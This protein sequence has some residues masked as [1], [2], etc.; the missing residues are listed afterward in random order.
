MQ[1]GIAEPVGQAW[2]YLLGGTPSCYISTSP[3]GSGQLAGWQAAGTA[4]GPV[5]PRRTVLSLYHRC[6]IRA[7]QP[8]KPSSDSTC[9]VQNRTW[10]AFH[11][12]IVASQHCHLQPLLPRP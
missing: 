3:A 12:N 8:S 5:H 2:D 11:W 6:T 1:K 9:K 10:T 4:G 7:P